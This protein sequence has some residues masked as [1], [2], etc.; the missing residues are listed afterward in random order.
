MDS[1]IIQILSYLLEFKAQAKRIKMNVT[2]I[3]NKFY[4]NQ[5][6]WELYPFEFRLCEAEG[7]DCEGDG[8]FCV[9]NKG[10]QGYVCH[11]L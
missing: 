3:L 8:V 2:D 10:D 1:N 7:L 6:V 11:N 4:T 5:H 9:K